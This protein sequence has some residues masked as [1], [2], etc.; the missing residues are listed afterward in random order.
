M[1]IGATFLGLVYLVVYVGAI[2]IL[3]LFIIMLINVRSSELDNNTLNSIPL[4]ICISLAFIS[5]L[6]ITLCYDLAYRESSA[7]YSV[8]MAIV[9]IFAISRTSLYYIS[10]QLYNLRIFVIADRIWDGNLC[11][12][13]MIVSLGKIMYTDYA[14]LLLIASLVLLLSM[15]GCIVIT[16]KTR[17][18]FYRTIFIP[19]SLGIIP[20]MP[21]LNKKKDFTSYS[22]YTFSK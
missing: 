10:P 7:L 12:N 2:S 13:D 20:R 17:D 15:I 16:F 3:L 19:L 8:F 18:S 21:F 9:L 22:P 11:L 1:M 4:A 6:T 5:L 14:P